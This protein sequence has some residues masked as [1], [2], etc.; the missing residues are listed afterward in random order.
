[1]K[2]K[3]IKNWLLINN[4]TNMTFLIIVQSTVK[5]RWKVTKD[6][7]NIIRFIN[8]LIYNYSVINELP[9]E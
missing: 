5:E 9:F 6:S 7:E 4:N 1:M 2:V 8:L 3:R